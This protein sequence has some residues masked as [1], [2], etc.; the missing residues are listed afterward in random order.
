MTK[1][2]AVCIRFSLFVA[3]F[4][5]S[6]PEVVRALDLSP[7][8]LHFGNSPQTVTLTNRGASTPLHL[9]QIRIVGANAGEASKSEGELENGQIV[10][11]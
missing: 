11:Q 8:S 6:F 10:G 9:G 7:A 5:A 2:V 3:R 1:R 4:T